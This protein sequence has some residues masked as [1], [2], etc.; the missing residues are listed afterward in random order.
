M[1]Y[2]QKHSTSVFFVKRGGGGLAS[3]GLITSA[4]F[5]VVGGKDVVGLLG[6]ALGMQ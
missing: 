6:K 1:A 4:L 3:D 5:C 2:Q